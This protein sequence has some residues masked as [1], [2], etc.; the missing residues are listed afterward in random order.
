MKDLETDLTSREIDEATAAPTDQLV[1][2]E[3][4]SSAPWVSKLAA[5][6]RLLLRSFE[7]LSFAKR[8]SRNPERGHQ[9]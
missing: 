4:V 7:G 2:V 8:C 6:I 9:F 5:E 1:M 3:A